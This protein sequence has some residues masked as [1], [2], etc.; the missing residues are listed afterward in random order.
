MAAGS[1]NV[2]ITSTMTTTAIENAMT[3]AIAATSVN[4]NIAM[5]QINNGTIVVIA[6]E[7]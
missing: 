7:Q 3:T 5:C 1:V 6:V 2:Q 4:A